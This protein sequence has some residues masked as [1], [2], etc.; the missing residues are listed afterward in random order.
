MAQPEK[1]FSVGNC[2]ASVFVN[3]VNTKDGT[4]PIKSVNVQKTYKDQEGNF[5]NSSSFGVTDIPK[6][7]LALDKAYEYLVLKDKGD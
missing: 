3:Q 6:A 5:Q 4:V 1:R 2:T 7:R